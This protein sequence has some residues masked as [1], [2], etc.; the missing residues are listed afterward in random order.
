ME[1]LLEERFVGVL[2]KAVEDPNADVSIN[3]DITAL[4]LNSIS[5][6]KLIVLAEEEFGI[7]FGDAD[8]DN[9][10]YSG[11]GDVLSLIERKINEQ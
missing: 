7:E 3:S 11:L 6:I 10:K 9:S 1:T 5:F 4:G 2:K 8:L